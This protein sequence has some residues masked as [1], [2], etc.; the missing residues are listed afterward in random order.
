MRFVWLVIS[1]LL[2]GLLSVGVAQKARDLRPDPRLPK[3]PTPFE[4]LQAGYKEI[5]AAPAD[6]AKCPDTA[7][8]TFSGTVKIRLSGV[9]DKLQSGQTI[10]R[11]M[12][13]I[14][15]IPLGP[16]S[17]PLK[18]EEVVNGVKG[19]PTRLDFKT[20]VGIGSARQRLV[21]A[22]HYVIVRVTLDTAANTGV[23]FMQQANSAD[24]HDSRF[25][26]LQGYGVERR[27]FA[28][29]K[30]IAQ[31]ADGKPYVEFAVRS[32]SNAPYSGNF[33]IGLLVREP[34][35]SNL[36]TPIIIDPWVEN[37]G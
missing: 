26:V 19:F 13:F 35:P 22:T 28:C 36:T 6:P 9:L 5:P 27:M 16:L 31:D 7:G 10:F 34:S 12:T 18:L 2:I 37:E 11:D 1:L 3:N 29:R 32:V 15:A 23:E 25:A 4:W 17:G 21:D 8:K 30:P 14:P 20:V 33:G 24:P